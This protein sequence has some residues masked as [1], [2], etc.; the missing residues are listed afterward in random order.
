MRVITFNANGIRSAADK[1]FLDWFTAQDADILC[2]QEL[3]A[4][5]HQ[6]AETARPIGY[7]HYFHFAEKPGYSGVALYARSKPDVVHTGLGAVDADTDWAD[8]DAEGRYLQADF[9]NLSVI[10]AYFPSGSSSDERQAVK[11]SF[12]ERFLPFITRLKDAGR[13]LII[14]GDINIAH[15]PL[16]LKN[17]RG[18]RKNSGFL[19]EERAWF[20]RWLEAGFVDVFRQLYPQREAYSWWSNRGAARDKD[21]GWRIDYHVCTRGIADT[22]QSVAMLERHHRFSDHT[23]VIAD[24]GHLL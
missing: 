20:G 10:S 4:H 19:P 14:C 3:K 13:E 2:I 22:V 23:P 12:L 6:V 17:W 1:G 11:M 24:F 21:V 9:G 8:M 5:H 7:H 16:D 18:N 15:R